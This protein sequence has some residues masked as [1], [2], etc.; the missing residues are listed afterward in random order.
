MIDTAIKRLQEALQEAE[1][2][3]EETEEEINRLEELIKNVDAAIAYTILI[4]NQNHH[5]KG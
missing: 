1:K 2:R 3:K 4:R 5:K